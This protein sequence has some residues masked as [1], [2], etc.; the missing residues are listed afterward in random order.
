MVNGVEGASLT[1]GFNYQLKN[2]IGE[3]KISFDLSQVIRDKANP[4]LPTSS[5]LNNKYSD[6]IGKVNLIC[7]II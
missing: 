7:L 5:T 4:D 6:I 1:T 3:E 2:K